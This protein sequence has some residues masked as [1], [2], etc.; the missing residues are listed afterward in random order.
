MKRNE[1]ET[2]ESFK[3]RR[4]FKKNNEKKKERKKEHERNN[5]KRNKKKINTGRKNIRINK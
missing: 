4:D 5:P 2:L 1:R 3:E